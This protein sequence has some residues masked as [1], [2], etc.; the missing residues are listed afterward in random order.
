MGTHTITGLLNTC[1]RQFQDWSAD[2]RLYEHNRIA[3][4]HLFEPVRQWL[5]ESQ[6][7]PVVVAMDD[8]RLRKT[9]KRVYGTKYMRDPMGPPFRVNFIWAQRFLQTSMACQTHHGD[10]RMIPVDWFHA[11]IP[12]KPPASAGSKQW[13]DYHDLSKKTRV[14]AVGVQRLQHMRSWLDEHGAQERPLW[15]VVDGSFTNATVLKALPK[16]ATLV[17]RIRADAKLHHLPEQHAHK[18]RNCSYGSQAPTPEQ[19]RQDDTVPWQHIEV[20]FA[21][22][23][24]QL[25]VKQLTPLRWRKAGEHHNLQVIVIAPTPYKVTKNNK[26]MYRK[27]AY[28]ICTDPDAPITQVVQRYIWRWDIEV[29]HRDE[30]TL[31]GVGEAQVRTSNAVQNVTGAAVAA[32]AMLLTA[33]AKCEQQSN[34]WQHLA[35]PKWQRKTSIRPTTMKLIQ[36][37]RYELWARSIHFSAFMTQKEINTKSQKTTF[38]PVSALLYAARYS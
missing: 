23:V 35:T 15:A 29:N 11:P 20:F 38:A 27:P 30:K 34:S 14:S 3:P 25:R 31:L 7:G 24:R 28:L 12:A 16:N 18:G 5:C 37:L 1:G 26:W 8:T 2:Y 32:Y 4:E 19:L 13:E 6:Q 21:G 17:G 9:G 36:N 33:A 22:A 10:A